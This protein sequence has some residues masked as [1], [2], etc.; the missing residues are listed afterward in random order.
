MTRL[1]V[2]LNKVALIRNA[3]GG[4][5]PDLVQFA[6]D[7]EAFG[8]DGIT[9]H[10]RPDERH[11]RYADIPQLK[12]VVKTE[13]NIEGYPNDR[14][15]EMV[16]SIKPDQ[17]TLVPD[18]PGVLTSDSGWDTITN[19][20]RLKDLCLQ[21]REAGIRV[22]IFLNPIE[23][24]VEGAKKVGTD[25]IELYTGQYAKQYPSDKEK[26]ILDHIAAANLASQLNV[27]VNAGHDLNLNNLKYYAQKI[28]GLLEVSIGQALISDALYFGIQNT[29]QLYKYLL[30]H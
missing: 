24:M 20:Q 30:I 19:A 27:G 25:R 4:N 23:R 12:E 5:L 29:I 10:P 18:P 28:P 22:S 21:F 7:C 11:V 15:V 16:L 8:A 6:Q 2:N 3:R 13:F 1:S 9:V 26:A 17:V 14:F